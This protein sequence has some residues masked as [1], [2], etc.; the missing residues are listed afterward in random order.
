M[1]SPPSKPRVAFQGERGA[2]SEEAAVAVLGEDIQLVPR[3]S[4]ESLFAA[5]G[6]GVSDYSLVP[7]ENSIAGSLHRSYDLLLDASLSI[8]GESVIPVVH[9]LIGCPGTNFEAIEVIESH[10]MALAQCENFFAANPQIERVATDDTAGSV[11]RVLQRGDLTRGAIAGERAARIYGGVI[12]AEHLEDHSENYT[13]FF[14]LGKTTK[15]QA[16]KGEKVSLAVKLAHQPGALHSALEV[17]ARRG[18]DL[19]KIESR[20]IT[21][22]PW[23]YRF[24]LDFK[25]NWGDERV[26]EALAELRVQTSEI[27]VLGCYEAAKQPLFQQA[28][29][30]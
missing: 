28:S 6:E 17:F 16:A 12:L 2:F 29:K 18:I 23:Q 9:N 21:G 13:R 22:Q 25:G 26:I 11:R 15:A 14:L 30:R 7:M 8:L 27:K 3:A 24:Y 5:V 4:L 1:N 20:P 10:P 19:L